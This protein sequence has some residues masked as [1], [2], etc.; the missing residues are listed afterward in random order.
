MIKKILLILISVLLTA[1][2]VHANSGNQITVNLENGDGVDSPPDITANA[3]VIINMQTGSV[4]YEKNGSRSVYPA[5]AVKVMTALLVVEHVE[6]ASNDVTLDTQVVTSRTVVNT[7]RGLNINMLEGEIF[8]VED[9]LNAILLHGANDACIAIAELIAGSEAAFVER[10]NA[11]ARELGALNTVFTNSHGLHCPNMVT[12]ALDTAKIALH[13]S[14]MPLI[15]YIS[16]ATEYEIPATNRT[17][18]T[19]TLLNR[20]HFVS[21]AHNPRHF[22]EGARGMNV[23]STDEGG[24][25]LITVA[26]QPNNIAYLCVIMGATSTYSAALGIHTPNSFDDARRLLDWAFMI[27]SYRTVL[28]RMEHTWTVRVELAANKDEVTLVP[29]EDIRLLLP[30]NIN[31][32]DE[33][34]RIVS[35]PQENLIAPIDPGQVL[36]MVSVMH[37]GELVGSA[38]LLAVSG[39]DRSNVLYILHQ[40]RIIVARPWFIASVI[41]F[42]VL[43]AVYI[44]VS[45]TRRNRR[46]RKRFY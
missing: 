4:I 1:V 6:D 19:R 15:M 27:Y 38:R 46:E 13:A 12:T 5:S 18:N 16:S 10:M 23:G 21:R 7:R 35:V 20:N 26:Q 28:R 22:Y 42:T 17:A 34:E 8:T 39:V 31:I 45:L 3:A 36:G 43:F 25:I 14:A 24:N 2:P 33:I 30:R 41:I 9:L 29:D 37:R 32:E 11:R 44:A 40:I